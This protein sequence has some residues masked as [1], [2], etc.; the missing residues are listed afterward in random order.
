MRCSVLIVLR[1]EETANQMSGILTPRGCHISDI[2]STGMAGLRAA[3]IHPSDIAIVGFALADMTGIS[4]AENL[5]GICDTSVLLIVP[6]EQMTFA[7][8]STGSL[9]VSCLARPITTQ[10]LV[11]SIDM[12]LQFRE[13]YQRMQA[14][15]RK[16]RDG[17]A[18]RGL[19][20]RAKTALMKSLG[21]PEAEAWRRMQKQSM[22]TGKPLEQIAQHIL[23]I[24]G[25]PE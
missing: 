13:R 3:A 9:D 22:D 5:K 19:A 20:E 14:E 25:T 10:G 15:A 6:P 17:L 21:L 11:T 23:D 4:F 24:Y 12:M 7:R 2:C 16:L 8:E 18:R 1:S